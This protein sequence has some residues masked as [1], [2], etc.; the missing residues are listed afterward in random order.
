MLD[1][2][3]KNRKNITPERS[4]DLRIKKKSSI[5]LL[6]LSIFFLWTYSTGIDHANIWGEVTD[7][8]QKPIEGVKIRV[9]NKAVHFQT[10]TASNTIRQTLPGYRMP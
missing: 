8:D 2:L 1:S 4:N 9:E 5:P 10:T 7:V 3:L 6:V